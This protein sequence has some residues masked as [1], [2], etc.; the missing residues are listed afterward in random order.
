MPGRLRSTIYKGVDAIKGGEFPAPQFGQ[1]V[2]L[3]AHLFNKR[4]ATRLRLDG[5]TG[6]V[7]RLDADQPK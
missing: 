7:Q 4:Y 1:T 6:A 5:L 3:S 2:L